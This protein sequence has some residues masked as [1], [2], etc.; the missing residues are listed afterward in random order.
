MTVIATEKYPDQEFV[1]R[2]GIQLVDL[3][4]LLTRSDFV[5]LNCPLNDETRGMMNR[6]TLAKMKLGAV[7]INTARGGLVVEADLVEAL[8]SGHLAGAGL[9]VLEREPS[10]STN[11]LFEFGN[12]VVSPHVAGNDTLA[13]VNMGIEAAQSIIDLS[14]GR[15]PRDAVVNKEL[16]GRWRW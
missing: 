7:L 6:E 15:W 14:R 9:D 4:S 5:S 11:P 8:R 16:Q 10:D 2:H 3:D 12:V 13:V 1:Q